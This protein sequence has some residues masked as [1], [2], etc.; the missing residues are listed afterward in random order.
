M[1]GKV[2]A[3]HP[4]KYRLD[5]FIILLVKNSIMLNVLEILDQSIYCGSNGREFLT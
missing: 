2:L 5:A 1:L 3:W 4:T